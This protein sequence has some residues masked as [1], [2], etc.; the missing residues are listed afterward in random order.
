MYTI[1]Q[2]LTQWLQRTRLNI[3]VINAR[4]AQ[5]SDCLKNLTKEIG[6]LG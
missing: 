5:H 6:V 2:Q 4:H 1:H 3:L